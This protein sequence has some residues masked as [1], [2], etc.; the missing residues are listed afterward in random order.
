MIES[1]KHLFSLPEDTTYLNCAYMSPM[2]KS[3]EQAGHEA[4]MVKRTPHQITAQDFFADTEV[5]RK[6]YAK[7]INAPDPKRIVTISSVS[8]GISTVVKNIPLEKGDEIVIADEQF[9]SNYY[10]WEK[11]ASQSGAS[12]K[13]VAPPS[14]LQNRS[15]QWNEN[16]L[17]TINPK[18]KVVSI[19][20]THW[21]DGTLFDLIAIRK[22]TKSVGALLIIDGTQ[23]V[24]ALPFDVQLIQPDA[25]ICTGYKWLLG[26]YALG[27][28]YYGEYFD[29][30]NPLEEN[31][32]NRKE[33]EDFTKLVNYQSEYQPGALRYEVGEHSN[34]LL[35][36]MLIEA[37]NQ[38]NQWKPSNIQQYCQSI[39]SEFVKLLREA[40]FYIEDDAYRSKHLFGVRVPTHLD[41]EAIDKKL[42]ATGIYVSIRGNAIRIAPHLYNDQNDLNKLLDVLI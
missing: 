12:I 39:S 24:G 5:L 29:Q 11:A 19:A 41:I 2:L 20:N 28:A 3:V 18:T 16:I 4:M 13:T 42:R 37:I 14:E 36:P 31:W 9:P 7:L 34:F 1:Q 35:L 17:A 23:S 22:A 38:L 30:G 26:P 21:A 27:V 40:D 6:A 25:L 33:S 10:P 8:Y 32:I 15:K